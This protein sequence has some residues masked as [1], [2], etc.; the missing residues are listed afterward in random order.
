M[1]RS[2]VDL[3]AVADWHNLISAFGRAAAGCR[4]NPAAERF[5]DNLDAN[6]QQLQQEILEGNVRVGE[7]TSFCIRDP[8][9]RIIHAPCFRERVLHH[10]LIAHVGPVLDR[11]L[12]D[13]TFACRKGKGTLAAVQRCQHHLRR[14]SWYVQID[15][16]S[17]FANID[18]RILVTLLLRKFKDPGL[19]ALME[20]LIFSYRAEPGK[21]LPI[22]ALTSQHFANYYLAGLD[23]LLLESIGVRGLVRYMDDL[24]WCCDSKEQ[25]RRSLQEVCLFLAETLKLA[26]K[27]PPRIGQSRCG[28]LFCGFRVLP[29]CLLLS[30]RRKRRY[31]ERR[32][33]WENRYAQGKISVE[34]LQAGYAAI[35]GMT[36]HADAL[37]WRR[38]QLRRKPTTKLLEEV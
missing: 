33:Y 29:G 18:H 11:T 23:R 24:L 25:A 8:K 12:V 36:V 5:R 37:V 32:R 34:K 21:G 2:R 30:R 20:Q 31:I 3:S 28:T 35:L 17:F 7:M 13:D 22:G 1:K 15:I 19:L 4:G 26:V 38:E 14:F 10:A 16:R 6:L 27:E 9:T